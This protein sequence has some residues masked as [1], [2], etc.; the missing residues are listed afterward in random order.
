MGASPRAPQTLRTFVAPGRPQRLVGEFCR[1]A[2]LECLDARPALAESERRGE[3]TY[4]SIDNHWTPAAHALA[5][6]LVARRLLPHD[7]P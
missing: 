7:G 3:R 6:D 1:D 2:A 5:A 4:Y